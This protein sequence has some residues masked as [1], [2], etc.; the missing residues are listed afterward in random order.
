[1]LLYSQV[2]QVDG[3]GQR[4]I[5]LGRKPARNNRDDFQFRTGYGDTEVY[6]T[7]M[8]DQSEIEAMLRALALDLESPVTIWSALSMVLTGAP[9]TT[10]QDWRSVAPGS[11]PLPQTRE[12]PEPVPSVRIPVDR[13]HRFRFIV[14]TQSG[15][16]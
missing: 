9:R 1:M 16:S 12:S 4:N 3:N 2:T 13:E 6:V 7:A 10:M 14:N 5:L 11:H 15:G 8:W